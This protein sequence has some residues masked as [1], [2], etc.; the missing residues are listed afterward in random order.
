MVT[1]SVESSSGH[2]TALP[3]AASCNCRCGFLFFA[4]ALASESSKAC[5][6]FTLLAVAHSLLF[7]LS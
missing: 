3:E 1:H 6:H 5:G 2:Q 7:A 4:F